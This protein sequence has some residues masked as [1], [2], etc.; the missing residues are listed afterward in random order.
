MPLSNTRKKQL[1]QFGHALKPVVTVAE[2][3][4]TDNVLAELN[5]ALDDHELI[6]VKLRIEER[7]DKK[8]LGE[9]LCRQCKAELVQSIGHVILIYR[10]AEKQNPKLSNVLSKNAQG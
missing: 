7:E 5:R 2:Q 1:R 4:L 9:E 6:K 3:G 10:Q 8:N